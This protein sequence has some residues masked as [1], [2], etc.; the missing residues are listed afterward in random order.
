[1]H[2]ARPGSHIKE[3]FWLGSDLRMRA[4]QLLNCILRVDFQARAI[5]N[6]IFGEGFSMAEYPC[7]RPKARHI[8]YAVKFLGWSQAK[9]SMT[10][11]VNSGT[12]S[13]IVRGKG[14][15]RGLSPLP[16]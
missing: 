11:Q 13:K 12:V 3:R 8:L 7:G 2:P 16:F 4:S 10:F 15:Y 14:S 9:A 5:R 1:M 6:A